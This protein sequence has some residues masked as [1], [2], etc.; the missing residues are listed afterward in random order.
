MSH[1]R[2]ILGL[3]AVLMGVVAI[4]TTIYLYHFKERRPI[5]H[6]MPYVAFFASIL[7]FSYHFGHFDLEF[8]GVIL[9]LIVILH[10]LALWETFR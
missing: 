10:G 9:V 2:E 5:F 6:I 8:A 1:L 3:I 7:G 4:G